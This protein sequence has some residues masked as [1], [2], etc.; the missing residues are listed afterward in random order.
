MK[1]PLTGSRY[2]CGLGD[3]NGV[4]RDVRG[5]GDVLGVD[6]SCAAALSFRYH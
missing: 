5:R 4:M 3:D 6:V 1:I 2:N